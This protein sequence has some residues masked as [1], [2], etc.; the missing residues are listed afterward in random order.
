MKQ[1][2]S[3]TAA[4]AFLATSAFAQEVI[5]DFY[6]GP[7]ID[8]NRSYVNQGFN[9]HV[10][11]FNGS[12]Q[13][14]YTDIYVP[15]NGGFD[16]Q[17]TR[18][19]N[20]AAVNETNPGTHYG[21]AGIGWTV[22]FGR[23]LY[24]SL[25]L[26]CGTYAD[27]LNSPVLE[28]PDGSTQILAR[29]STAGAT[30]LSTQRWRA[31]CAGAAMVIYSPDGL[32]YD[33]TQAVGMGGSPA[34]TALY[35]TKIT[36]RN[37]N[38][39]TITYLQSG[40]PEVASVVTSES[41]QINFAYLAQA[42]NEVVRR[43]STITSVD[44]TGSRVFTY[45]YTALASPFSGYQLT[46]VTRPD[47]RQWQY[48]YNG[49]FNQ[50]APG[51]FQMREVT[52]PEGGRVTYS[53][54]SST[55]DYVQFDGA[56]AASRTSVVK[57]KSTSDGGSWTF[58]YTPG[59]LNN[60]DTTT[61]D[62]PSGTTTYRHVGPNYATSGSLWRVGLL[63]QK[64]IGSVQ[65]ETY[66]WNPQQ[67][68]AQQFKRPGVW[69]VTRLDN[70]TNAPILASKTIVRDGATYSTTYSGF[71][72]YGN[73]T[74]AIESGP[75][76]GSRTTSM[77]YY[78][79][80]SLWIVRQVRNQSVSGGVQ[81]T[82]AVD[83][84]GNVTGVTRDG[85][86]TSFVRFANGSVSQA[87]FP[88]SLVHTY[89]A[90]KRGTPQTENQPEGISISRSVSDSGNLLSET[91]GRG[92][93]TRY[94]YDGLSRLT[95]ITPP[96]GNSTTI[97]YGQTSKSATRGSLTE[98]VSY[99]GFGR[100]TS[101]T[102]GGISRSYQ[103]DSLGRMTFASNPGSGSG[104]SYQHDILDRVR[105]IANADG[106]AQVVTFGAGTKSERN[107]RGYSTTYS[108][109]SYGD[110]DEQ[111]LMSV[112]AP[113]ASA[114]VSIGRN[115]RDQVTSITQGGFTRSYGYDTRGFLTS[116]VNPETGTT[117]YGRD[118]ASNM[119]TRNVGASGTTSFAY[120]GQ[121]RIGAITYSA[122]TPSVTKTYTR[123]HKLSSVTSSVA[124][125][126]YSY[127]ANDNLTSE[128]LAVDGIPFS[129]TYG[130]NGNDQ[131]SSLTYPRSGRVVAYTPNVLG[132]PTQ[133]SGFIN[134]VSY[135]PSGLISQIAYANTTVSTYG[136]NSRLWPSSFQ[137][138]KS[139][140]SYLSSSY[141]YDGVGNLQTITDSVDGGY[142]RSMGYDAINRLTSTSGPWGTGSITYDG[143]GNV[144][145]QAFGSASLSYSYNTA[146][147]LSSVS[148]LRSASYSYDAYGNVTGTGSQAYG[149]DAA[150]NMTCANCNDAATATQFQYDGLN[151]RVSTQKGGVKTY[152][153]YG[154]SGNL[155]SEFTPAMSNRLAEHIY[156]GGRRIASVGPAPTSI[157]LPAATLSV[158]AGQSITFTA[159]IAGGT[160]PTGTVKFFDGS[161][162]LGTANVASAQASLTTS[163][164]ALG[165]HTIRAEYSGDGVNLGSTTTATVNVLSAT[166][167]SGPAGGQPYV[168]T[169]GKP[170]TL[171]AT[172]NGNSPTGT[173]SFYAGS[174][175]LGTA[176]LSGGT[177][178]ITTTLPNAGT[179]TVTI[180]YS[181]DANNAPS[182]A[183]VT[184]AVNIAPEVLIPI[185]QLLLED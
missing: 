154:F 3:A 141:G 166:T 96:A 171:A 43:I 165:A 115:A 89:S 135:H 56:N 67:I 68:S 103:H 94:A 2:K 151:T 152:E 69:Q 12:L 63:M 97:S 111:H 129:L 101:V 33:M 84:V 21:S 112:A 58:S 175:L 39:A 150:P 16:I 74:S 158:V 119:T 126:S 180:V 37:N 70:I 47:G 24:K 86:T 127:D 81:I 30:L 5:P 134:S 107:E 136:Q 14:H 65:T 95:G 156:L 72:S 25:N 34:R 169:A 130:Y 50:S 109:R 108:H 41:H 178:S 15:G 73:P 1:L 137:T 51:G 57:S 172:I 183:T 80:T 35:A 13:L 9:E 66:T 28:L 185:L 133:V 46:S 62:G 170:V 114:N 75:G 159:N 32:R 146:N 90:Y 6:K 174:T 78:Q 88:R 110:P 26:P 121:N 162:L 163:F 99:D 82:R 120:D 77:T 91:N 38:S 10:D 116:V 54:G 17:V 149:Y 55:N 48:Q 113:E 71:D 23:V 124:A 168:A 20:S 179:Y 139:T 157:A 155:L 177:G 76:G 161:T 11:P 22:H 59:S 42:A 31:E 98:T 100:P 181:G 148:G 167:V 128:S 140:T 18:S 176:T 143:A 182:T 131:L 61:V 60:Y 153:F 105:S 85:V 8:V 144:R 19:Y 93:Q 122:G 138:S 145:S 87:T 132:R 92:Y 117:T 102:V 52:F 83:G 79:N 184:L 173:I 53:Y 125:R 64:Q 29:S 106:T 142:N 45:G 164:Q 27:T 147:R 104:T 118:D 4:I 160:S 123:T 49:N 44:A 7:G 40:R 36:D